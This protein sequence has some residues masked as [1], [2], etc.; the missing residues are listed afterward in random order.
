[1]N[2]FAELRQAQ[3]RLA[4]SY[5]LQLLLAAYFSQSKDPDAASREFLHMAETVAPQFGRDGLDPVVSD[6]ASQEFRD[7]LVRIGLRARA[8]ATGEQLDPTSLL[9]SWVRNSSEPL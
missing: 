2:S 8:V 6:L 3:E 7:A 4:E 9:K 1:V 5:V